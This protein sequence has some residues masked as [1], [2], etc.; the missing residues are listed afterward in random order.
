MQPQP[1]PIKVLHLIN[2]E[3]YAGAERVQD[4]LAINL[5]AHGYEV[6]FACLKPIAFPEARK[7]QEAP[8][9]RLPMRSAIDLRV[10]KDLI[11]LI[12]EQRFALIHTHYSRSNLLGGL[13]SLIT[14]IPLVQHIHGVIGFDS[15]TIIKKYLNVLIE[16]LAMIQARKI[17]VVSHHL[18]S[19]ITAQTA[20]QHK[21][22]V[23]HNG[24]PINPILPARSL[25]QKN[26]IIGTVAFWRPGKGLEELIRALHRLTV[27][28]QRF[29]LLVVGGFITPQYETK[30]KAIAKDLGIANQIRWLGATSTVNSYL[31]EMDLFVLPSLSEGL[32]MVIL[33]AMAAGVPVVAT[34]VGGISEAVR[35]KVDGV[36]VPAKDH[37]ALAWAIQ[38][39]HNAPPLWAEYRVSSH[40]RQTALFSDQHMT[41]EVAA[42]YSQL[43]R[44][45]NHGD[46]NR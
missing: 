46:A 10:T 29:M 6:S 20:F 19:T 2:G 38:K 34:D 1:L 32:P 4:L 33:E 18:R 28:G 14:G 45:K 26:P 21:L 43:L 5:P 42:V 30:I 12:K 35:H 3:Y 7:C 23:I 37:E 36:L 25:N 16:R 8:L 17:I 40:V 39:L 31:R 11:R 44:L 24:V 9:F 13:A 41:S 15:G 22:K 27:T